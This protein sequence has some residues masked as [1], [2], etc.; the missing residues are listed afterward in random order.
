[1]QNIVRI[2]YTAGMFVIGQDISSVSRQG[3]SPKEYKWSWIRRKN[4][5]TTKTE[6]AHVEAEFLNE[7]QT[8]VL[9][10]FLPAIHIQLYSLQLCLEI[11]ISSNLHNLFQ[12]PEV[13]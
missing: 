11:S 8:Q 12:F 4:T 5:D 13:K 9:R 6:L 3:L 2:Q 10:V 1:M 7:I